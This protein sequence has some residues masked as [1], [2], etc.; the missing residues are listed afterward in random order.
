MAKN[1]KRYNGAPY[2]KGYGDSLYPRRIKV[3]YNGFTIEGSGHKAVSDMAREGSVAASSFGMMKQ[4][5]L[6]AT[7]S[8]LLGKKLIGE[9][10]GEASTASGEG[11]G[12]ET[13]NPDK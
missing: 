4:S 11:C 10:I 1:N 6:S 9:L 8:E 13:R 2:R 12:N 3:K 5:E 7:F